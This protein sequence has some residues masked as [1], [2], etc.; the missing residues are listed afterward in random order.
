MYM[1]RHTDTQRISE[2]FLQNESQKKLGKIMSPK[3]TNGSS[4][5]RYENCCK[6]VLT[7]IKSNIV[8]LHTI[9]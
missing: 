1:D 7:V 9:L 6:N 5:R 4:L 3:G 2:S 8:T